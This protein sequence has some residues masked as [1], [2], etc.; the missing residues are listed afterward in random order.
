MKRER[1]MRTRRA[2]RTTRLEARKHKT[3][4]WRR[5][6]GAPP[7]VLDM[8]ARRRASHPFAWLGL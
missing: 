4:A 1:E 5:A 8:Y 3:L 7:E 6:R 2:R